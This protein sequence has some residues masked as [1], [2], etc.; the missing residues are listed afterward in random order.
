MDIEIHTDVRTSL[1][2]TREAIQAIEVLAYSQDELNSFLRDQYERNPLINIAFPAS[3][4]SSL[5]GNTENSK[6]RHQLPTGESHRSVTD[7][8]RQ[9]QS[10]N[11]ESGKTSIGRAVSDAYDFEALLKY[12]TT[13]REHLHTQLSLLSLDG[14]IRQ[15]AG[16]I[17]DSLEPDGY[18]RRELW[19]MSDLMAVS[20]GELEQAIEAV[21]RLEPVG[22]AARNLSECLLL[23]LRERGPLKQEMANLLANLQLVERGEI[24]KLCRLCGVEKRELA[25]L[26]AELRTL[27]PRPGLAWETEISQPA[28]P[29]ILITEDDTGEIQIELNPELL[30][31][32]LIDRQYY[33]QLSTHASGREDTEFLRSCVRSASNLI[34]NLDQRAKTTLKIA[35]VVIK[36]HEEFFRGRAREL[37]PLTQKEVACIA[38]VHESTVSRAIAN[39]YVSCSRGLLPLKSLFPE[40]IG[41]KG[42]DV[43]LSATT[44]HNRIKALVASEK[45]D[46]VLS[47]DRIVVLLGNEGIEVARRTVA[48]YRTMLDIPSSADRRRLLRTRELN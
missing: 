47:D 13:L 40:A 20:I 4:Q 42:G 35:H 3:Q 17:I 39:K 33:M 37:R 41:K 15:L 8:M 24:Q 5:V 1:Q 14:F 38:G 30:P 2:V 10:R 28:L 48:K 9:R 18:L 29:D 44:I 27:D 12:N 26:L 34:R 31:K 11:I 7:R 23:Q 6:S 21:Q 36:H 32:V 43:E 22:V 19:E 46:Q 25:E 16:Q 45:S